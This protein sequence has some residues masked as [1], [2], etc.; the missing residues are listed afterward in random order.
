MIEEIKLEKMAEGLQ[1]ET[2]KDVEVK[3]PD[4]GCRY[5][6]EQKLEELFAKSSAD[7]TNK[8]TA[9]SELSGLLQV[10]VQELVYVKKDHG[11]GL[12]TTSEKTVQESLLE[13]V[14]GYSKGFVTPGMGAQM[15]R[16]QILIQTKQRN[17]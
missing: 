8:P 12:L 7:V 16:I 15:K 4:V 1:C 3:R 9:D 2:K 10:N 13:E 14:I 5:S 17:I 11:S 6:S